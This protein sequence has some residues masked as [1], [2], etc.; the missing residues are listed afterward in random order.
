VR[1]AGLPAGNCDSG[2]SCAYSSNLSWRGEATP[3][4]KETDPKLVFDRLFGGNDPMELA[5]SRAKRDLYNKSV[6]DFVAEDAKALNKT[7]GRG[8]QQKLDEYLTAVREVEDRIEKMR[9]AMADRKPVPKPNFAVPDAL[10]AEFQDHARLMCDLMVLAFQTDLTRVVTLPLANDGS[11]R[12]YKSIGVTEGHHELSHHQ[13][14]AAKLEKL[15][16]IN[17]HHMEQFAYLVG[18]MQSVKEAN[19]TTLLDNVMMVYGSGASARP[20]TRT[21]T[22]GGT[23]GRTATRPWSPG[24]V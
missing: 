20:A 6:L 13:R 18:K 23:T 4:A 17:T 21:T 5:A 9:K 2:Y 12:P 3:N 19:G 10:P 24:P 11:N 7:L 14:N 15:K 22:T 16:K 8:D 1:L